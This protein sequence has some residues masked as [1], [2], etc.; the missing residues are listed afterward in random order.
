MLL[1]KIQGTGSYVH[2]LYHHRIDTDKVSAKCTAK[3]LVFFQEQTQTASR[4]HNRTMS[5]SKQG[6]RIE[7]G[8]RIETALKFFPSIVI[9]VLDPRNQAATK[10]E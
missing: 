7:T 10:E 2:D 8:S 1:V 3:M 9:R 4:G 6:C 5:S